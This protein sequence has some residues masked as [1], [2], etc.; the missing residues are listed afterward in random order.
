M[1]LTRFRRLIKAGAVFGIDLSFLVTNHSFLV[2][3]CIEQSLGFLGDNGDELF[4]EI[5]AELHRHHWQGLS[6]VSDQGHVQPMSTRNHETTSRER[7][8][9]NDR[10]G[11]PDGNR[12]W[13]VDRMSSFIDELKLRI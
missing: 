6:V 1:L 4:I 9:P 13:D 3:R 7:H 5:E 11:N 10:F 2:A 8:G 12:K